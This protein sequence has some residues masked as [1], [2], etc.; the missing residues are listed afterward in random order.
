MNLGYIIIA[1]DIT[2]RAVEEYFDDLQTFTE[3]VRFFS[4]TEG[5]PYWSSAQSSA[6]IFHT[7]ESAVEALSDP[8][9]T[10]DRKSSKSLVVYPPVMLSNVVGIGMNKTSGRV[11]ILIV[12][13]SIG[14]SK[15]MHIYDV[16]V[17]ENK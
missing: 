4:E 3:N 8:Y 1:F 17:T 14:P 12:P 9:F 5:I 11:A 16:S 2:N 15:S 7:Y 10:V 13:L 6:K